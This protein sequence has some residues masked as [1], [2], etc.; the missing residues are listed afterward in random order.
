MA[1]RGRSA[2]GFTALAALCAHPDVFAAGVSMYGIS[3]LKALGEDTHKLESRQLEKLMGGTYEQVKN[4]YEERSPV[5]NA[6]R[7]KSPLLVSS[8]WNPT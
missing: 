8:I 7:I 3:D 4:V 2:G 1:I 5:N 6:G